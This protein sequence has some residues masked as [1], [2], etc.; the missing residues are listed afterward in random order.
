MPDSVAALSTDDKLRM[1]QILLILRQD[2]DEHTV[3]Q[4]M[5]KICY[6]TISGEIRKKGME[7]LYMNGYYDDLQQLIIRNKSSESLSI[8]NWADVYQLMLDR[9]QRR[10]PENEILTRADTFQTEEPELECLLEFIKTSIY[11]KR[12]EYGRLGNIMEK[13]QYL[14]GKI[15]D[16]F[17]LEFFRSR[18]YHYSFIYYLARNEVIIAR[19]YAFRVLMQTANPETKISLH[20]A[21]GLSYIFDTYFQA[22]YHFKEA[23]KIAQKENQDKI[24]EII[25]Q[26]NI[27]FIS[28]HFN[29][30]EGVTSTDKSEQ[31]HLEIAKGN[32]AGAEAILSEIEINTPFRLYY[33]GLAKKDKTILLQSY[34]QFIEKR[35]D[36]F[37]SR[38]PLN[39]LQKM[40][41]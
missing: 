39:A 2:Y 21:L 7:F 26:N 30:V 17:L 36:Y 4:L 20:M 31:A 40:N 6:E 16:G 38:L 11:F 22:M 12:C 28:A 25:E 19:K 13:Q 37:F 24:V 8:R 10:Y 14:F 3:H 32:Y 33:L 27:P 1:E 34:N 5:R 29:K 23:L 41:S 35:S 18:S 15:D 9:K